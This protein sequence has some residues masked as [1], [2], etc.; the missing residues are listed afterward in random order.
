MNRLIYFVLLCLFSCSPSE[1][2]NQNLTIQGETSQVI[3]N[4]ALAKDRTN[5]LTIRDSAINKAYLYYRNKHK[6]TLYPYILYQKNLMHF[7]KR[8]YDS[9][10]VYH[11]EFIRLDPKIMRDSLLAEEYYLMGYLESQIRQKHFKAFELYTQSKNYFERKKDS[12]GIAKTLLNL[13]TIQKN[14][15][16]FFGSKETLVEALKYFEE[17]EGNSLISQCY[18]TLATN[19]RKLLN[20]PDA[21]EYYNLAIKTAESKRDQVLFTNNLAVAHIDN[22]EFDQAINLL[23]GIATDSSIIENQKE[24]ARVLDNLAY[25]R[26]KA[27]K[28]AVVQDF[29]KPLQLRHSVNDRRGLIASYTHLGEFYSERN[30]TIAGRYF[31]SVI[32]LSKVLKMPK[33]EQDAL[34]FMMDLLPKNLA[35][36]NRYVALNDSLYANELKVKTQFAKY[37]Y[38]N[39]IKQASIIN[40]ELEKLEREKEA[41]RQR[42]YKLMYLIAALL[43]MVILVFL[44]FS[45]VQ[46]TKNLR[47]AHKLS[48][49]EAIYETESE[50][51]RKIHDEHGARLN[52]TMIM[53]QND[54]SKSHVL[55]SLELLYN[56]SRDLAREINDV[57]TGPN[58]WN[59][60][61]G[62]LTFRTPKS[63]KL[64]LSGGKDVSWSSMGNTSKTVL[65][66]ILQELMINLGK[67]SNATILA[68]TFQTI[69]KTLK[70]NYEDDGVGASKE[71]LESKNGLRNT[72]KRILAIQGNI[73]FDSKKNHG[74]RVEILIP[75]K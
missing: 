23:K 2:E 26:W 55:D 66:K 13:G 68:I 35:V 38:D 34:K 73:T 47:Q 64:F 63:V 48:R 22:G 32:Q 3:Q 17:G 28:N 52:Q 57:D 6:D 54:A 33:A 10:Q 15:N 42:A 7:T 43:L 14:H 5:P 12:L 21:I 70:I 53:V 9:L 74:F 40:L 65:F 59:G 16:D 8:E 27:G 67:H 41:S 1:H 60:L 29:Q 37:K 46:R 20:L 36:R 25:A 75:M 45:F 61:L 51:S 44:Y 19:H 4:Y 39:D 30:S 58:Y 49:L 62:M 50:L 69:D 18:N 31:D 56:H 71:E 24:Q 72:E 11:N